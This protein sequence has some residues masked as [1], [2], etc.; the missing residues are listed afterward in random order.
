MDRD[1]LSEFVKGTIQDA[2]EKLGKNESLTFHIAEEKGVKITVA[3][4]D[5]ITFWQ[6]FAAV[7]WFP[8][9]MA[10]LTAFLWSQD[11]NGVIIHY[12]RD[13]LAITATG[14]FAGWILAMVLVFGLFRYLR[15]S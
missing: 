2:V 14:I 9:L 5:K 8:I 12:V 10:I 3:R 4:Q 13:N 15:N 7:T 1:R 6:A 11:Q